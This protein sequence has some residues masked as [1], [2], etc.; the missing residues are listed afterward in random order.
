MARDKAA[1]DPL[2]PRV[3][4][5]IKSVAKSKISKSKAP[6]AFTSADRITA[7]DDE[8]MEDEP[9]T[10]QHKVRAADSISES[11]K[12]SSDE[13]SDDAIATKEASRKRIERSAQRKD[14]HVEISND[15]D[16]GHDGV[17]PEPSRSI[18]T[19]STPSRSA[20]A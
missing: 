15:D 4:K 5:V 10:S 3:S 13:D 19:S 9:V 7:S 16:E 1:K 12:D 8:D 14:N 11:E 18:A 6:K 2:A 20:Q 17:T